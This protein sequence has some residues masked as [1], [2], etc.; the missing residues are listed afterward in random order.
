MKRP[1][2]SSSPGTIHLREYRPQDLEELWEIDRACYEPAIAYSRREMRAFLTAPGADCIVAESSAGIAGFCITARGATEGYI[3][4]I[5][6]LEAFRKQGIGSAM[7]A[8]L[9]KRLAANG[10]QAVGLD[11]AVDNSSAIAFWEKHGYRK[12]G[13]RKGYYP[14]GRDAFA[15]AKSIAP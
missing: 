9:E 7:L 15:M 8:E 13:V 12:L 5:D 6:V 14:N 2:A 10:I 1:R 4:T 11:T 3:V